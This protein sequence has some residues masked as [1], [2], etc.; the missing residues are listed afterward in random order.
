MKKIFLTLILLGLTYHFNAQEIGIKELHEPTLLK[1][2]DNEK[3]TEKHK[4]E[5]KKSQNNQKKA[6]KSQKRA[7]KALRK[8]EQAQKAFNKSNKKLENTQNKYEALK[9]K[10]KLSPL[11]E[12]KWLKKI[13]R[14]NTDKKK[15]EIKLRKA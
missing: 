5:L 9:N 11:D 14:L 4:K 6:E 8:K 1:S 13:E 10:G 3:A 15:A 12:S 7:E 2:I